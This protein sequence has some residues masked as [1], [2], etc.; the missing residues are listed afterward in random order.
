MAAVASAS[1]IELAMEPTSHRRASAF[2]SETPLTNMLQWQSR[3]SG[4]LTGR[5]PHRPTLQMHWRE[6]QA[7]DRMAML[8]AK[9]RVG[10]GQTFADRICSLSAPGPVL[11]CDGG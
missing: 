11:F 1:L 2:P 10:K 8:D 9:L 6:G 5:Y 3:E 7:L 4:D